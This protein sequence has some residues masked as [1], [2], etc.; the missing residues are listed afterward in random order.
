MPV[1]YH[2]SYRNGVT[3]YWMAETPHI[4]EWAYG[5]GHCFHKDE[6]GFSN[7]LAQYNSASTCYDMGVF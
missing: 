4:I 1:H 6:L 7:L 3:I 5:N 2:G